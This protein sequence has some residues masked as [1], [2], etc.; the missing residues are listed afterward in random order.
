M[1]PRTRSG[2]PP[3]AP[4]HPPGES[5]A[6]LLTSARDDP[7]RSLLGAV[8]ISTRPGP[9]RDLSSMSGILADSS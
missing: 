8:P 5:A 4:R 7:F 2:V 3:S 9:V 6:A 1:V